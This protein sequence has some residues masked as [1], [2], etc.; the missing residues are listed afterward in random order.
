MDTSRSRSL[1]TGP[2]PAAVRPSVEPLRSY[3]RCTGRLVGNRLFITTKRTCAPRRRW[4]RALARAGAVRD[5]GRRAGGWLFGLVRCRTC[6]GRPREERAAGRGPRARLGAVGGRD[7][8]EAEELDEQRVRVLEHVRGVARQQLQQ[9]LDLALRAR[10][11]ALAHAPRP[12]ALKVQRAWQNPY[13]RHAQGVD[14][15]GPRSRRRPEARRRAGGHAGPARGSWAPW[16]ARRPQERR[17]QTRWQ[18][19]AAC[20]RLAHG[21]DDVLVVVRQEEHAPALAGRRQLAQR[22]VACARRAGLGPCA[23]D[24]AARMGSQTP[25]GNAGGGAAAMTDVETAPGGRRA[26]QMD[27]RYCAASMEKVRR[28]RRNACGQ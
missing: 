5:R 23:A 1:S 28:S 14:A 7:A 27:C 11:P 22:L 9:Q 12:P 16:A 20:A 26:P 2:R 18:G 15:R 3:W 19:G 6:A 4:A 10:P 25:A 17:V 24:L 8:V 21:L 13:G